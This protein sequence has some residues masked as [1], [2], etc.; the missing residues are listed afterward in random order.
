RMAYIT[1]S[2]TGRDMRYALMVADADGWNPQEVVRSAEPL[3]S[4]SWSPDGT[5]LAYVSFERGNSEVY[6]QDIG[7]GQRQAVTSFRGINGAPAFSPDGSRLALTLSK[8]GNPDIYVLDLASRALRQ[9]TE[10]YGIDTEPTWS[11]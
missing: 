10:H 11:A 8:G 3:L 1:A 4:P 2:G 9:L 5:R 7:T 6:V